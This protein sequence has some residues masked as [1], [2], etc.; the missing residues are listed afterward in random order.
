MVN[1]VFSNTHCKRKTKKERKDICEK[2]KAN[3]PS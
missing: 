3:N 1:I 2:E